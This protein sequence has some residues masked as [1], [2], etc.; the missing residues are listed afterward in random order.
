MQISRMSLDTDPFKDQVHEI[1]IPL[2]LMGK[3]LLTLFL[4]I[5]LFLSYY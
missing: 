5:H 3:F 4:F 1:L 2:K